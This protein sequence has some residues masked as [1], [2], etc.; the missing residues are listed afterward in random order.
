MASAITRPTSGS[1]A[2]IEATWAISS[3]PETD[4]AI[5]F[6]DSTTAATPFSMPWRK[7]CGLAPAAKFLK[8]S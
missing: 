3:L 6:K 8:P 2:E 1:L 4:L 7:A 5:F